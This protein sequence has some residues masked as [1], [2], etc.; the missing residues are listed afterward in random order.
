MQAQMDTT[1]YWGPRFGRGFPCD[2]K[3]CPTISQKATEE[4]PQCVRCRLRELMHG[5]PQ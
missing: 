2:L 5:S 3:A 4:S 1:G